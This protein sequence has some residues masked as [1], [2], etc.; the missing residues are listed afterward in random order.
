MAD[1]LGTNVAAAIVPFSTEDT[2]ATHYAKYGNGG[3]REVQTIEEMNAIP[4]ARREEG[5]AVYVTGHNNGTLF[6]LTNGEFVEKT[7]GGSSGVTEERLQEVVS[8]KQ[9]KLTFDATPTAGSTNPVTSSGIKTAIDAKQDIITGSDGEILY[10]NGS[11]VFT[12]MLL[13]EGM[14]C[15]SDEEIEECKG[16]VPTFA[17]VFSSWRMFSQLNGKDN[18]VANDM[19]GW[20]YDS[21]KDTIVQPINSTSFTGYVS[22]KSYSNYDVTV[23]LYSSGND[24]D[25]MGMVAAFA[26][27]SSGKEHTLAFIR[28][29]SNNDGKYKWI[30]KVDHCVYNMG[31]TTYNQII[32]VDNTP[33]TPKPTGTAASTTNWN[34]ATVGVGTVI[35]MTRKGNI[36]TGTCSQ[37]N[38]TTLDP[39]TTITIDL[40]AL[41]EKYPV[42][43][44]FKGSSPWG[45]ASFSQPY[46]MYE[47][48]NVTNPDGYI[49]D[50]KNNQV[51]QFDSTSKTWKPISGMTPLSVLGVGRLS[52]NKKTNKLYYSTAL[53]II[54]IADIS[55][56]SSSGGS[57]LPDQTDMFGKYLRTDGTNAY[58]DLLDN[59]YLKGGW[60][61][62]NTIEER[63]ALPT[64]RQIYGMAAYV[65]EES[66][67]YIL[68]EEGW[69][70][71]NVF[72]TDSFVTRD[73]VTEMLQTYVFTQ[74]VANQIWN[75]NH[76]LNNYPSVTVVDTSGNEVVGDVTYIDKNNITIEFS[77]AFAGSAYLN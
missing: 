26:V 45:Y 37:F 16:D 22:P 43:N 57:E 19:N 65:V 28:S 73:E 72:N 11:N 71:F 59:K 48:I 8:A 44:N 33:T 34:T 66:K 7:F 38:S 29:P 64:D 32:L 75:I 68:K 14:V 17:E 41:S 61:E 5:M 31:A 62:F 55:S 51:L 56:S 9:D 49:Y 52:F 24:N 20:Y 76:N 36:I 70:E 50:L 15:N 77:S 58:W 42:L 10:H 25:Q 63:D 35:N 54:Q 21:E 74:G 47:N 1:I 69:E 53:G 6:I 23:R 40:D 27:D 67:L 30:C 13:N 4:T 3:W 12:Q 39:N 60:R 18:A 46:S 2:F